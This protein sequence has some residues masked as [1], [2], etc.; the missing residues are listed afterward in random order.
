ME[1]RF[2]F[3]FPL[4]T[5]LFFSTLPGCTSD[6]FLDRPHPSFLNLSVSSI[7]EKGAR[8]LAEINARDSRIIE[9]GFV[10]S[11]L[12]QPSVIS[13]Q[14]ISI[15]GPPS[16]DNFSG[17]LDRVLPV[18]ETIFVRAYVRTEEL[19]V[20]SQEISFQSLGSATVTINSVSPLFTVP[21]D[22]V[23]VTGSRFSVRD[24]ENE[25]FFNKTLSIPFE[26]APDSLWIPVPNLNAQIEY[27]IQ[28]DVL[29]NSG[30]FDQKVRILMPIIEDLSP[31]LVQLDDT[32]TLTGKNFPLK[33]SFNNIFI[34][35]VRSIIIA[36]DSTRIQFLAPRTLDPGSYDITYE[37]SG[38]R[39]Q[40]DSISFL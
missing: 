20:Y 18:G 34:G 24:L 32:L 5:A 23:L 37:G 3:Y 9:H 11:R 8:C 7:N 36:N 14:T 22:T 28:V 35:N 1:F 17:F 15:D 40:L 33:E 21:G 19:Y 38:Q 4:L 12:A 31:R 27:D 2:R 25:V 16:S 39:I 13:A 29:G 30:N 6:E 26:S 10:W